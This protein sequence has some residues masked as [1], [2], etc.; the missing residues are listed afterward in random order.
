MRVRITSWPILDHGKVR[1]GSP[2]HVAPSPICEQLAELQFAVLTHQRIRRICCSRTL[3]KWFGRARFACAAAARRCQCKSHGRESA[4]SHA[5]RKK[6]Q[7]GFAVRVFR[8]RTSAGRPRERSCHRG[9]QRLARRAA[10]T[11][12]ILPPALAR[13]FPPVSPPGA[14]R[15][16]AKRWAVVAASGKRGGTYFRRWFA[17]VAKRRP[18]TDKYTLRSKRSVHP[19]ARSPRIVTRQPSAARD[20]SDGGAPRCSDRGLTGT[21]RLL[22]RSVS[23]GRPASSTTATTGRALRVT[24]CP[25]A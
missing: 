9:H 19:I 25:L 15:T 4:N 11:Q 7:Q 18:S 21:R 10:L 13:C 6:N 5:R 14:A 12:L 8:W 1:D 20:A 16:L 17:Q 3:Y 2:Q 24:T 23:C 22:G